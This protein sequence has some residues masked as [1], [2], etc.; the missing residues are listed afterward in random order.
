MHP[1]FVS[2]KQLFNTIPEMKLT[3]YYNS[4]TNKVV[5]KEA[6]NL[7]F[8]RMPNGI[9]CL[10]ANAYMIHLY[11]KGLSRINHG[12]SIRQAAADI[13]HIIR[14]CYKN[15]IDLHQIDNNRFI[16]F[17]RA[18][19]AERDPIYP[20]ARKRDSNTLNTIGR[21]CLDFL[22]FVGRFNGEDDFVVNMVQGYKK[23][24]RIN[25]GKPSGG[26]L[27]RTSWHHDSFDTSSP[28]K[29][30]GAISKESIK[31]LYDI[32][33]KLT[34][35]DGNK[36]NR[37]LIERRRTIM[38]RLLEMTGA[39]IGEISEIYVKDITDALKQSD[40]KLR[41]IT[42]KREVVTI[43]FVPVLRQDLAA[44]KAYIKVTRA[45]IIKDTIGT[46]NDHGY[47]FVSSTT[48]RRL[49]TRYMS[50]E[51]GLLR[52]ATDLS[53]GACAHM[54]RHRFI[55][56]LFVRLIEQYDYETKDE[57]RRALLDTEM[58]KQEV[59]QYTGHKLLKSLDYYIDLAFEEVGN[60]NGVMNS[61]HLKTTFEAFDSNVE[62]LQ[63][64]LA[65]GLPIPA[66][67]EKYQ[68]LIELRFQDVERI[69]NHT[70]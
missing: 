13:S 45:R 15:N 5:L 21:K 66:Y 63:R 58:L 16:H 30:R 42:L 39:R 48:G 40:P 52:R 3:A 28:Q 67:L 32:I 11:K 54:F 70:K 22:D 47:L 20:E 17:I 34:R 65:S 25:T 14:Y 27:D 68:E 62:Q 50:N 2:E 46:Q 49:S 23:T 43:R 41:L 29:K 51:V 33:P 38:L 10:I 36:R 53:T 56:K 59:Q 26:F 18:L 9:P 1:T 6:D 24:F 37:R 61:V 35:G 7:P 57:F 64:D 8:V 19:R 12:G 55:T 4:I 69:S 44:L 31:K 60:L